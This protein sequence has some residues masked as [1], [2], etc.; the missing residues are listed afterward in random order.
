MLVRTTDGPVVLG[1]DGVHHLEPDRVEG[2]DPLALFGERAAGHLRRLDGF[3]HVGDLLVIS[4]YDPE[5]EEVAAFEELVGS[6]GGM[7]GPQTRPF[8]LHPAELEIDEEPIVGAPAVHQQLR[9]WADHLGV[10]T[11]LPTASSPQAE[12]ELPEPRALPLVALW[13]ALMGSLVLLL[14]LGILAAELAGQA[15]TID[16]EL[17]EAPMVVAVGASLLGIAG[18]AAGWGLWRRRRWAWMLTLF[19]QGFAVLQ[20]IL[21]VASGGF[22]GIV[23]YGLVS[24]VAALGIFYYLTRP[25]VAAVFGRKGVSLPE[26]D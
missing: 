3:P 15:A 12:E 26:T 18:I 20:V 13:E 25:H 1:Q 5:L 24:A 22:E 9:A 11:P 2:I 16:P 19:F 6:H 8:L 4:S 7:G 23:S 14:G 10:D 17:G 21:A